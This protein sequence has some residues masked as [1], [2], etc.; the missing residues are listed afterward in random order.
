MLPKRGMVLVAGV[1]KW[2]KNKLIRG[3][4]PDVPQKWNEDLIQGY[5]CKFKRRVV[6]VWA[7]EDCRANS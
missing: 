7:Q 2:L 5:A 6:R 3:N 4:K 1:S